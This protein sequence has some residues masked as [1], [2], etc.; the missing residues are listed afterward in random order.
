LTPSSS[1]DWEERRLR[2]LPGKASTNVVP[3]AKDGAVQRP[4]PSSDAFRRHLRESVQAT[5]RYRVRMNAD[6]LAVWLPLG[7]RPQL[8]HHAEQIR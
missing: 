7:H 6:G 8:L 1:E 2:N 5:N 3:A 4:G